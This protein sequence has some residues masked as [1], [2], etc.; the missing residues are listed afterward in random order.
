MQGKVQEK[1]Q[2]EVGN[3]RGAKKVLKRMQELVEVQVQ[4]K[5]SIKVKLKE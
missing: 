2:V 3:R 5:V 1:G 4:V